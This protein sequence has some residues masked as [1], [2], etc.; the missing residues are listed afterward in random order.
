MS[1]LRFSGS[2]RL[3]PLLNQYYA[4][5]GNVPSPDVLESMVRGEVQAAYANRNAA[6][7][8]SMRKKQ[9]DES[10]KE[11]KRA[12]Q[13]NMIGNIGALGMFGLANIDK[14]LPTVQGMFAPKERGGGGSYITDETGW[15]WGK[16]ELATGGGATGLN[17]G[18]QTPET[19]FAPGMTPEQIEGESAAWSARG[20]TPEDVL[21]KKTYPELAMKNFIKPQPKKGI[22]A[23]AVKKSPLTAPPLLSEIKYPVPTT[24]QEAEDVKSQRMLDYISQPFKLIKWGGAVKEAERAANEK[25]ADVYIRKNPTADPRK[26]RAMYGL[27]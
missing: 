8:L 11:M 7:E 16:D 13:A 23:P 14:W 19:P 1:N 3:Q 18:V 4:T 9:F 5:S 26:V 24:L 20:D 27:Y 12:R 15:N 6:Q 25:L 22:V 10:M 2:S 17:L 21:E